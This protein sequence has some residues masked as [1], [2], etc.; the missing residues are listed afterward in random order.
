MLKA[1]V[2]RVVVVVVVV[3]LLLVVQY[4]HYSNVFRCRFGVIWV[5]SRDNQVPFRGNFGVIFQTWR[6]DT[7]TAVV[8]DL[9]GFLSSLPYKYAVR[10]NFVSRVVYSQ[11]CVIKSG[12]RGAKFNRMD[13]YY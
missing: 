11:T 6:F 10:A 4:L 12:A 8:S 2:S 7:T 3:V 1:Q 13:Y 5:V 9:L